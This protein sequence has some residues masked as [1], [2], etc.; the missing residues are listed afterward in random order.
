M[1]KKKKYSG[2]A[3]SQHAQEY[4]VF[5]S[6]AIWLADQ[7]RAN[8]RYKKQQAKIK[9]AATPTEGRWVTIDGGTKKS[10]PVKL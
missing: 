10:R 2:S 1:A 7:K 5:G 9:K 8:E 4:K 3:F 6:R